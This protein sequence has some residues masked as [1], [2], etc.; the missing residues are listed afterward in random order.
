VRLLLGLE[1]VLNGFNW[2][3]KII[4]PYPS[5][6]DYAGGKPV[7]AGLVGAMIA[8]GFL[9][10]VVKAVELLAGLALLTNYWVPLALVAVFSVTLNVFFVDVLI[11]THLR[12]HIMG[13]GAMV[14]SIFLMIAYLPYYMPM[15]AKNAQP[16]IVDAS[17][18]VPLLTSKMAKMIMIGLGLVSV[19]FGIVMIGWVGV[20]IFQ[21]FSG[22][23]F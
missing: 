5:I 22:S 17:S 4:G 1:F 14:M 23:A 20:M 9:F 10:H 11:S 18:Q 21:T 19:C 13:T 15:L 16:H 2:W 3:V 8:T 6:S 7:H 12:A